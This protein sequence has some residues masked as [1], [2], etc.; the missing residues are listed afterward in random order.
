MPTEALRS[1]LNV[2]RR[3]LVIGLDRRRVAAFGTLA[4]LAS[5]WWLATHLGWI[6][7]IFLPAPEQLLVALKGLLHDGYLDAT[8]WQHLSTSLWRVLVALLAAVNS[9]D[10]RCAYGSMEP[11]TSI[12]STTRVFGRRG[13]RVTTSNSPAFFAVAAMVSSRSSSSSA[14]SRANARSLRKATC[15]CR[16]S[17]TTSLR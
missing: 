12:R 6:D 7:T 10:I 16:T 14:P 8:L 3:R 11:P 17:S 15:I 1:T 9:R 13:G 2:R 4:A 5:L